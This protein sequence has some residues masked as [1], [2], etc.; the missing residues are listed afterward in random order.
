M[1]DAVGSGQRRSRPIDDFVRSGDNLH[2][3]EHL[4]FRV[5]NAF[6]DRRHEQA[7]FLLLRPVKGHLPG[8]ELLDA[9]N[10][11][12]KLELIIGLPGLPGLYLIHRK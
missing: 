12:T 6:M 7:A 1:P 3:A 4:L 8:P 11:T 5:F 2:G 9:H 10:G